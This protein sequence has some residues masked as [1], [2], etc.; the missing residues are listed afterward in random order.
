MQKVRIAIQLTEVLIHFH[1]LKQ[2]LL[3]FHEGYLSFRE[4]PCEI[5]VDCFYKHSLKED[6]AEWNRI[7]APELVNDRIIGNGNALHDYSSA[8]VWSLA[9]F[10]IGILWDPSARIT[11]STQDSSH[12]YFVMA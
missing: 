3:D 4:E 5:C 7:R 10:L 9:N 8:D 11:Y 6:A 12:K 2:L 1:K